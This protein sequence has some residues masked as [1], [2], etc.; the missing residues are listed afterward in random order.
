MAANWLVSSRNTPNCLFC[1]SILD[2]EGLLQMILPTQNLERAYNFDKESEVILKCL[3]YERCAGPQS[4]Q[5]QNI[6][7]GHSVII[8]WQKIKMRGVF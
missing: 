4:P 1:G 8:F 3:R 6:I 2:A 5:K 7:N